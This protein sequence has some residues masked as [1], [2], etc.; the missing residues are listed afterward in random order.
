LVAG[1]RTVIVDAETVSRPARL[2]RTLHDQRVSLAELVPAVLQGLIEHAAGR[3]ARERELPLLE[4]M[5]VTGEAVPVDL[6]RAWLEVY[7]EIPVVNAYGPTEASDDVV[8]AI[9]RRPPDRRMRS[10]PIGRPLP[11]F[12]GYV[13]DGGMGLAPLG[14]PGELCIAGIGLGYGYW[15]RPARTASA[16]AP[17]PFSEEPGGRLYRTGDLVR[18]LAEGSL[19]FLGRLDHQ[20]KVRGFRIEL[21]EIEGVLRLHPAVSECAVAVRRQSSGPTLVAYLTASGEG[22]LGELREHVREHLPGHMA[23]ALYVTLEEMPL[24]PAGK[25]DRRALPA[26]DAAG[27]A[28]VAGAPLRAPRSEV[29]HRLAAIWAEV[30][31]AD[32]VG[33]DSDF[34]ELGGHS[35][36]ATQVLARV[37]SAFAVELP[38]RSLFERSTLSALAGLIEERRGAAAGRRAPEMSRVRRAGQRIQKTGDGFASRSRSPRRSAGDEPR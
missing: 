22:D 17:D 3:A 38:L 26:P 5:M 1:G 13:V 19:D 7:P 9:F 11:N 18:R 16:F 32:R 28:A 14:V 33:I 23:P 24:T 12:S 2:W 8:Q 20:V 27:G 29:E 25:I 34:F 4:W 36:L 10:L 31:E 6:V 21:G 35:L 15:R 30:L 37:R